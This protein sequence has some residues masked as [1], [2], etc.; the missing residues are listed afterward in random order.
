MTFSSH[1][2][3][4]AVGFKLCIGCPSPSLFSHSMLCTLGMCVRGVC[5]SAA[6]GVL[7]QTQAGTDAPHWQIS[8]IYFHCARD[9]KASQHQLSQYKTLADDNAPKICLI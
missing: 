3:H 7:R 6:P 4:L 8:E 5:A 2:W 1:F 9:W